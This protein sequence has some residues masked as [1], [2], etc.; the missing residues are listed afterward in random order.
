MLNIFYPIIF[1]REKNN[2]LYTYFLIIIAFNFL[3]ESMLETQ[4]G[5]LFYA[6]F[7]SIMGLKTN[8]KSEY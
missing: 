1:Y 4:A 6:F 8:E 5:V 7:N 3:S 2:L